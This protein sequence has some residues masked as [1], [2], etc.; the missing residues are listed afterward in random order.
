MDNIFYWVGVAACVGIGGGVVLGGAAYAVGHYG[1][2]LADYVLGTGRI[3]TIR[4]ELRAADA[5]YKAA[6]ENTGAEPSLSC[7]HRALDEYAELAAKRP[8]QAKE[9]RDE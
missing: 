5:L 3:F 2:T 8:T 9:Q 1:W 4:D 6:R 7:F